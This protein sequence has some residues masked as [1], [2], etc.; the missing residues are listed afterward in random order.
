[1]NSALLFCL[2]CTAAIIKLYILLNNLFNIQKIK[3]CWCSQCEYSFITHCS[4][5]F[6]LK[7]WIIKFVCWPHCY[8]IFVWHNVQSL[9]YTCCSYLLFNNISK[10]R[11]SCMSTSLALLPSKGPTIPAASNWSIN[12]PARL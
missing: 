6:F 9:G 10:L 5:P 12:R 11:S 8:P 2:R 7:K 4:Y 3:F 1:M